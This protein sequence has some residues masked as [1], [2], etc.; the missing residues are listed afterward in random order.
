[1]SMARSYVN[2]LWRGSKIPYNAHDRS[3]NLSIPRTGFSQLSPSRA[4]VLN[5]GTVATCI[6]YPPCELQQERTS[7]KLLINS[8]VLSHLIIMLCCCGVFSHFNATWLKRLQNHASCLLGIS[9]GKLCMQYTVITVERTI[10][11]SHN[12]IKASR[13]IIATIIGLHKESKIRNEYHGH[14]SILLP[15]FNTIPH[16]TISKI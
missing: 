10:Q 9:F 14:L 12:H 7:I 11:S 13:K 16:L 5:V 2:T 4:D 6:L 1:M 8:L 15:S 3:Q